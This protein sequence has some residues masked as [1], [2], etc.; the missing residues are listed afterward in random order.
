MTYVP[1]FA[2]LSL[3]NLGPKTSTLWDNFKQVQTSTANISGTEGDIQSRKTNVSTAISP[4]FDKNN[5][6]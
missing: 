6:W 1:K 5:V 3:K 2:G 4:A